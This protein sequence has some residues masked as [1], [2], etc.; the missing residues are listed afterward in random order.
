M[1]ERSG[2]RQMTKRCAAAVFFLACGA[3]SATKQSAD[4]GAAPTFTKIDD[5]EGQANVIAWPPPPGAARG[6]W[7][8]GTDCSEV[9]RIL[10]T[11]GWV[12]PNGWSY[13]LLPEPYE[14]FPGIVSTHAARFRTTTAL[15][16]IWGAEIGVE[17]AVL[18]GVE[19]DLIPNAAPYRPAS[20]GQPCRSPAGESYNGLPVDLSAYS[21]VT[22]WAMGNVTGTRDVRI[23]FVD[24][25]VDARGG[26]CN[27]GDPANDGDCFNAFKTV[28]TLGGSFTRYTI[29]FSAL[30]Q[31]GDWGYHPRSAAIDLQHVYTLDFAVDLPN[32]EQSGSDSMC[33]GG[34]TPVTFE[35]W[36]DD[37]YFVNK[38]A[39]ADAV[40]GA[41]DSPRG[42]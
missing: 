36:I 1:V 3:C 24:V 11:P 33:A 37:L 7:F 19:G 10:P 6:I 42:D 18:P 39:R 32:C 20:G 27:G 5:M 40:D 26:V 22:F 29:D 38:D 41:L 31:S 30:Q 21:G 4:G 12:E 28:L 16:S 25:N 23:E 8:T 35:L 15:V 34:P 17:L 9:D 13:A 2:V 14:T